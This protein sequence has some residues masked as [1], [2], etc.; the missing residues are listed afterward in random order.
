MGLPFSDLAEVTGWYRPLL[1]G[2]EEIDPANWA[3]LERENEKT[4]DRGQERMYTSEL[5]LWRQC[6]HACD[7]LEDDLAP[8]AHD[9][10]S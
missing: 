7:F 3:L 9:S 8:D 6:E 1:G 10:A 2:V 5:S 4:L